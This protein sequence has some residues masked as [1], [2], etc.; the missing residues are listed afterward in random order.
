MVAA[1]VFGM[2]DT[3]PSEMTAKQRT[4]IRLAKGRAEAREQRIARAEFEARLAITLSG[5]GKK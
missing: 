3:K 2:S 4:A 5:G 1:Y